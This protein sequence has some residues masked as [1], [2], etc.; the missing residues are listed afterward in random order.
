MVLVELKGV[1]SRKSVVSGAC[2][3]RQFLNCLA[4]KTGEKQSYLAFVRGKGSQSKLCE[5]HRPIKYYH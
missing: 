1:V 5:L 3:L 2:T 4:A